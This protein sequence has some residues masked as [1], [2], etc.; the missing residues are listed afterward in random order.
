MRAGGDDMNDCTYVGGTAHTPRTTHHARVLLPI[1]TYSVSNRLFLSI[2]LPSTHPLSLFQLDTAITLSLISY[3][4]IMMLLGSP[5]L[6]VV[7]VQASFS[8]ARL[9]AFE[10]LI[11]SLC[12][13][14]FAG[15]CDAEWYV[16]GANRAMREKSGDE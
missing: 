14:R 16:P 13:A 2:L 4:V 15:E 3:L 10:S 12:V 11:K 1:G 7:M 8:T 9:V 5:Y 6:L